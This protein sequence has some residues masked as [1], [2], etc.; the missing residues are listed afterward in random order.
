MMVFQSQYPGLTKELQAAY[1]LIVQAALTRVAKLAELTQLCIADKT[2]RQTMASSTGNN[3]LTKISD[4]S[5]VIHKTNGGTWLF[6]D[7]DKQPKR[8]A[9][10]YQLVSA[11]D[12][13]WGAF[14]PLFFWT[15]CRDLYLSGKNNTLFHVEARHI[16]GTWSA[17]GPHRLDWQSCLFYLL[18]EWS[19]VAA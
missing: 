13:N 6:V 7:Y 5:F 3:S 2:V 8:L 14:D 16:N 10:H 18:D 15:H 17:C 12:R 1:E 19:R 11:S 9:V 4:T